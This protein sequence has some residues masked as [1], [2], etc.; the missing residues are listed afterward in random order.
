[1]HDSAMADTKRFVETYLAG[2]S[3]L[4]IGDFGAYDVNG[5]VRH[6]FDV[7]SWRYVGVDVV[8]GPNVDH[9]LSEDWLNLD[10]ESFDVIVSISTLEHVAKPWQWV[11]KLAQRL[12]RGGLLYLN[13]PNTWTYHE[14]P[15]DCWRIWPMG[16]RALFDEAGLVVLETYATGHDTTGIAR[17]S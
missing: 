5:N 15:I 11:V 7:P 4:A 17:K 3:G 14:H 12:K 9:V 16:M 13:A 8:P 10:H 2:Q 6:L 1:M